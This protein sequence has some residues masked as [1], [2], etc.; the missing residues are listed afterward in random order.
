MGA[1]VVQWA[2]NPN[3]CP[4]G[5]KK[6]FTYFLRTIGK[7]LLSWCLTEA[8]TLTGQKSGEEEP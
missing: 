8:P 6:S 1:V 4:I 5:K 7:T 2:V 3:K